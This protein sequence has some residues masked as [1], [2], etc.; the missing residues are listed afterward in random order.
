MIK[1]AAFADEANPSFAGQIRALQRNAIEYIE[2]RGLDGTNIG[3]VSQEQAKEYAKKLQEAGIKVWSIGS[4][5]GKVK[6]TDDL[7]AHLEKLRHVCRLAKIFET[8]RI[9][10][11]SFF[12]AYENKD[13]VIST[14][15][16]MVEIAG[17]Y[18]LRLC[19]ENEK[20]IYGDT[21]ERVTEI[22][23]SVPGLYLIYDPANYV[24]VGQMPDQTLPALHNKTEYFH[25]KD[26]IAQT[27]EYVPAG[28]GDGGIPQLIQGIGDSDK[29]LTVEPHL[30]MF[31]GYAKID[32]TEMKTKFSFENN[33]QA[34]DFAVASLKKLLTEQNYVER[35]GGFQKR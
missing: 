14:L 7:E 1:L 15:K 22:A 3:D 31:D 10:I 32:S 6:I 26:V 29:V 21:L 24:D 4:P 28:Y 30:M 27:G 8:D 13:T 9:R 20:L 11:F 19:H 33:D 17:E 16:K 34:F 35:N 12:E 18:G 2:L 5:I 23:Q 25:I